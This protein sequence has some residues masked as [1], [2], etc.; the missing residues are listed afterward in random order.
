MGDGRR[1]DDLLV[2]GIQDEE[3]AHDPV[4]AGVNLQTI[5]APAD[6]G[7]QRDDDAVV[8]STGPLSRMAFEPQTVMLHDPQYLF[9]VDRRLPL[10]A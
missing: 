1:S 9:G 2:A 10:Q 7:A 4:V 8:G 3:D 5:R 6:V